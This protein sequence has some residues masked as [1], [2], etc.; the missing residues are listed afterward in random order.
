VNLTIVQ[1]VNGQLVKT[2]L[3]NSPLFSTRKL[4]QLSCLHISL[5]RYCVSTLVTAT[6]HHYRVTANIYLPVYLYNWLTN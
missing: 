2:N 6:E 1:H 4:D 3:T 5:D